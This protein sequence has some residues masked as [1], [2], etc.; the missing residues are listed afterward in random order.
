MITVYRF[1]SERFAHD[2]SGTGASL[3]GGRW[4]SVGIPAVYTSFSISLALVELFIHKQTY[5]DIRI[6]HLMEIT[7]D[8]T[9]DFRIDLKKL[10]KGWQHDAAYCQFMGNQLFSSTNT[11]AISVPS[12]IIEEENNL[13]LNPM[14]KDFAKKVKVK[15]VRPFNFDH[16]LFK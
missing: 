13:V 4:N 15:K 2:L 7:I 16:R 1:A 9:I 14:A 8:T 3:F 6:N 12:A 10:K 5:E 11:T